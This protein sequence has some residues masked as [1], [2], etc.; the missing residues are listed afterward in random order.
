MGIFESLR[1]GAVK[2]KLQAEIALLER[3]IVQKKNA[4]GVELYDKMS[5]QKSSNKIP[6]INVEIPALA[7]LF[8]HNSD[9]IRDHMDRCRRDLQPKLNERSACLIELEK[10]SAISERSSANQGTITRAGTWMSNTG[11]DVELRLRIKMLERDICLR[12]EKF[13]IDVYDI[14]VESA[15]NTKSEANTN[16]ITAGV[17]KIA[18]LAG[19]KNKAEKEIQDCIQIASRQVKLLQQQIE[20]KHREITAIGEGLR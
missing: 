3:Q 4:F 5:G 7:S 12:K 20:S 8:P 13:G 1:Q 17:N 9:M 18:Q 16:K 6:G 2:T 15:N 19:V 10:L 11:K 14:V